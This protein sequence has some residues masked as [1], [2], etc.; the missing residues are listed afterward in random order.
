M[1]LKKSF[2]QS[3]FHFAHYKYKKKNITYLSFSRTK[4]F[5]ASPWLQM[6]DPRDIMAAIFLKTSSETVI[7]LGKHLSDVLKPI[8]LAFSDT[9]TTPINSC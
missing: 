5:S 8:P 2:F 3:L 4:I 1:L 9:K 6:N 7:P